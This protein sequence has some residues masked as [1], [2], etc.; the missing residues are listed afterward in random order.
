MTDVDLMLRFLM[1]ILAILG[2]CRFVGWLGKTFLGQT[3][4]VMEMLAGVVLGPS[5]F[6]ALNPESQKWLFPME[7]V[8]KVGEVAIKHPSM[9]VLY[10]VAQIGL[11]FYMFLVGLEFNVTLVSKR[12]GP[13]VAVSAAGII[14]PFVLG[15]G[16]A[17]VLLGAG[18]TDLFS[19]SVSKWE[20]ALFLGAAMCI[21]AFPMLARILYEN[22]IAGTSMGTLALGAGATDDAT[23]WA[24]LAFVLASF[25]HDM[26]YVVYAIGGGIAY[27]IL[28]FTV[29]RRLILRIG[30]LDAE[31]KLNQNGF[32]VVMLFLFAGAFI[33]DAIGLYAVFG[34]FIM[35][36]AMPRGQFVEAIRT[37]LESVTVGVLLPFFFV[38]SGLNTK[39]G[40][41][42][43][44]AMWG[45]CG[46][47]CAA[48]IIGKFGGCSLAARLCGEPW[49]EAGAIG[50]LMNSRGLMEL[51]IINIGLQQ[52]LI[53]PT[54][55]TMLVIMAIITTLMASPIFR[56]LYT[57]KAID[58]LLARDA[59][60][61]AE[62]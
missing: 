44:P 55:F 38:Y 21:T 42:N 5:V 52:K 10:V 32:V 16:L 30:L 51:I 7:P 39:I 33:T 2:M 40:L 46:L 18:N 1:Q 37:R 61:L 48:A 34:A 49:R 26:K 25:K 50:A 28:C 57:R 59:A 23:A 54:L 58:Q 47:M 15:A 45:I 31:G 3:Q 41:L 36:G 6:G 24:L 62:A 56:A 8:A 20:A 11:I 43:T 17:W 9:Y 29:V 12:V 60:M 27:G 35:G 4:V 13:A 22:G 19:A 14:A 53:T